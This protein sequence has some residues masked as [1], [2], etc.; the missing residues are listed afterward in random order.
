VVP[1]NV[2]YPTDSGLLAKAI[3]RIAV[4]G[5]RIQAAGGAVRTQVRDRSRAAGKRAH[6]IAAKLRMRSAQ[7]RDEA[8]AVLSR[9]LGAPVSV[10]ATTTDGLGLTG[11][12][13]GRAAIA[14]ALLTR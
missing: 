5:Q 12:G 14:T 6:G 3:K 9:S 10:T 13:E 4:T 2:A 7:D 8:Q 11:R 1:A